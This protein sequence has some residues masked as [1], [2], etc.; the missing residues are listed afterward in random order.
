MLKGSAAAAVLLATGAGCGGRVNQGTF[1]V[2]EASRFA[3][4]AAVLKEAGPFIVA[5]DE[6]GLYAMSAK[7]TH[8][9]CTVSIDGSTLPCACHGSVFDLNGNVMYGPARRPLQHYRLTI[10]NG[11]VVVDTRAVVSATERTPV[12]G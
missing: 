3:L 6:G 12:E 5:R 2:G 8:L 4:G 1:P 10:T 7:C 11:S 9:G